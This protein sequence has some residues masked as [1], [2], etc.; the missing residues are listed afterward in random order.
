MM[1][2]GCLASVYICIG[3]FD[4]LVTF[5][6]RFEPRI[7]GLFTALLTWPRHLGIFLLFACRLGA[8]Q[9]SERGALRTTL[10]D[11]DNK[12]LHIRFGKWV[13]GFKRRHKR[14]PPGRSDWTADRHWVGSVSHAV[15]RQCLE[16]TEGDCA[17]STSTLCD[18]KTE[19]CK[20]YVLAD[21]RY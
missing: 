11:V 15:F 7:C 13:A 18:C 1:L 10:Q 19:L 17:S 21:F 2:N 4:G 16:G 5:V 20:R 9:I 12:S 6:G 8:L 3:T 14:T